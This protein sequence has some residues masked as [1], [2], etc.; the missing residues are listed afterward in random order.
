MADTESQAEPQRELFPPASSAASAIVI[1]DRCM[2]RIEDQHRVVVVAGAPVA[3]FAND[4]PMARA[5]AMVSLVEHGWAD[6]NDVARVFE[7]SARTLR[8]YQRR[9]EDEGLAGLGRG[10]GYPSGRVRSTSGMRTLLRLKDEGHSNRAIAHR[11]G[12][13]E[14]AVRKR[15]RRLRETELHATERD[16]D[17]MCRAR[18]AFRRW[19]ARIPA[20][21]SSLSM[22]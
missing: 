2:L 14:K 10:P 17:G 9:Y 1:N 20:T 16:R 22:N 18:R 19:I 13:S 7:V 5:H 4:D 3:H 8:R 11:L 12:I 6:Q 15:L 21:D